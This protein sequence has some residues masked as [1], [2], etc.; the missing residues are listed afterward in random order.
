MTA[1]V[2]EW[3]SLLVRW[4]HFA[5][6]I[7][8]IGASF[9]FIWLDDSLTPPAKPRDAE[10][11]VLGELWSVHGGGFYHNQKFLTGPKDEPLTRDLHWFKWEAYSTWISGMLMLAIVYYAN[12]GAFLI[13]RSVL[14][15]SPGA[16]IGI[17]LGSI[18]AGWLLYDGLCRLLSARPAL[19]AAVIFGLS[20][21]AAYGLQH[22]FSGRAAYIHIGAILGTIMVANVL[23]VIIPGQRKMLAQIRA[24]HEPD[25]APGARGKMRSVHNTYLTL[26]VL[27]TMIGSHYPMTYASGYGWLV[28]A[29]L[30]AAGVAVRY[31]FVLSHKRRLVVALPVGAAVLLAVAAIVALPRPA[32]PSSHAARVSFA[33]IAPIVNERCAVCHSAHPTQPGFASAP[34]GVTFDTPQQI[35]ANAQRIDV[36]AVATRAMPLGNLTGMTE[37][38]RALLGAWIQQGARIR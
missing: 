28:L 5:A 2:M 36:Q 3:M 4:F 18:I 7:S 11:G 26:P 34:L 31:F 24:G 38:E 29:L 12:S 15:L 8:W 16:A 13:D 22:V 17:S 6:G 19:L 20:V 37:S 25:P 10:R 32:A 30:G 9:Y 35:R 21:A 14:A 33:Q 1:Y 23:F 27:F